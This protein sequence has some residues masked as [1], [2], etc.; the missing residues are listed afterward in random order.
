MNTNWGQYCRLFYYKYIRMYYKDI[1]DYIGNI[2]N[3]P[4]SCYPSIDD[5]DYYE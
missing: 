1:Q 5:E 4:H 3:K 2:C